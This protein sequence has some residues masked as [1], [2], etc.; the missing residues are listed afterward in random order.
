MKNPAK[1]MPKAIIIGVS[2][3]ILVYALVIT[4]MLNVMSIEDIVASVTPASDVATIIFGN[5]GAAF[6]TAGIVI[7]VFG[8][9]NGYLLTG[10]RVPLAMGQRN[11]LP[12]SNQLG[13]V[14]DRFGIPS[15]ALIFECALSIIYVFSGTF[16]ALTNLLVFVL[17]IFFV[18]GVFGVFT[19][20]HYYILTFKF[21][22]RNCHY[23]CRTSC[24]L[25]FEEERYYVTIKIIHKRVYYYEKI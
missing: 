2:T 25:L 14:N 3:V 10:A 18:M 21:Y 6:I 1:E 23:P 7:S 12:Y 17:W 13:K 15:N 11:Q 9:L 22:N 19:G 24:V 20:K 5:G 8:A 16:D 4:A